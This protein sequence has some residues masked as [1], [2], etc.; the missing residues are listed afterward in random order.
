MGFSISTFIA[1]SAGIITG[2]LCDKFGPRV[3]IIGCGISVSIGCLLMSQ[4]HEAW[5]LY[6]FY[7]FFIGVG[8]GGTMIPLASIVSRWFF[9]R[10]GLMTGIA[11]AGTGCGTIIMPILARAFISEY[12]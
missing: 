10:R 11:V 8:F 2:R 7:G 3:I 9:L 12:D 5:Q 1:G 4:V 6:I